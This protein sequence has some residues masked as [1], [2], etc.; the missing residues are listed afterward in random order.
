[1]MS[2]VCSRLELPD[3]NLGE[4]RRSMILVAMFRKSSN[5]SGLLRRGGSFGCANR[6][7]HVNATGVG[8]NIVSGDV[9]NCATSRRCRIHEPTTQLCS[10]CG[11]VGRYRTALCSWTIVSMFFV[12]LWRDRWPLHDNGK[13]SQLPA[14]RLGFCEYCAQQYGTGGSSAAKH[15]QHFTARCCSQPRVLSAA[16]PSSRCHK[17]WDALR[18]F[19]VF[20]L[21]TVIDFRPNSVQL[22]TASTSLW[23]LRSVETS[24]RMVMAPIRNDVGG[25]VHATAISRRCRI[26]ELTACVCSVGGFSGRYWTTWRFC[27]HVLNVHRMGMAWSVAIP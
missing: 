9:L 6:L 17:D 19:P 2:K 26:H 1:M 13:S 8:R 5:P 21:G 25:D 23:Q 7:T 22:A 27:P 12:W 18:V 11:C 15:A 20:D 14:S 16:R 10:V 24:T 3:M 4:I